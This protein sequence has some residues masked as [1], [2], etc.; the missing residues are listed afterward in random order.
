[1]DTLKAGQ[2]ICN[3]ID[4]VGTVDVFIANCINEIV[5]LR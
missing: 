4:A 3:F 1:M 2:K 5:F